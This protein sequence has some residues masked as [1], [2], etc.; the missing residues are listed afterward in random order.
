M[1]HLPTE[2]QWIAFC[3]LDSSQHLKYGFEDIFHESQAL[4]DA[5]PFHDQRLMNPASLLMFCSDS[6]AGCRSL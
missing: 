3:K 2:N 6:Q 5:K 4:G 1:I